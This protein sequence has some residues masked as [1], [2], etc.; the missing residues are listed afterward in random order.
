MT[1]PILVPSASG[2]VN[3]ESLVTSKCSKSFD[4]AKQTKSSVDRKRKFATSG[5]DS[6]MENLFVEGLSEESAILIE[7][8][9][10]LG[11]VPHYELTWH[12]CDSW[13]GR[14]KID[15][16]RCPMRDEVQFLTEC[17]QE[18][19]KY[20]T[21][22]GFRSAISAYHDSIQSISVGKHPRVSDLLTGI[23][24]K[25]PPQPKLNFIWDAKKLFTFYLIKGLKHMA[26]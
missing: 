18:S 17:F 14:R 8:S 4:R 3:K 7:N 15:P 21:I 2:N 9:R 25:N 19:F 12:K 26:I 13:C 20:N 16:I 11:T 23:F 24:N 5:M 10:R 1:N 22:A 6:F